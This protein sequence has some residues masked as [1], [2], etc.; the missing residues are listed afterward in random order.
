MKPNFFFILYLVLTFFQIIKIHA[1][2]DLEQLNKRITQLEQKSSQ[3]PED[4]NQ[5]NEQ[6]KANTKK[7]IEAFILSKTEETSEKK[8]LRTIYDDGFFLIGKDDTLKI[9]GWGQID[10]RG[11]KGNHPSNSGFLIRRARFDIRGIL[12]DDFAYRLYFA[13]EGATAKLQEMWVE[14]RKY[15]HARFRVGQIKAPFSLEAMYSA[16]WIHFIERA[17]GPTNFAPFEDI[18]AQLFGKLFDNKVVYALAVFNGK[19]KNRAETNDNKDVAFRLVLQPFRGKEKCWFKQLFFG[20]SFTTGRVD[21][22]IVTKVYR[23]AGRTTF[24]NYAPG[25]EQHGRLLRYGFELEWIKGP[26]SLASEYL[27]SERRRMQLGA[28]DETIQA[29]S[30]YI[31][32]TYVLTGENQ[33]RNRPIK[34]NKNFNPSKNAWGAW[35]VDF[36]CEKFWADSKILSTGLATGTDN[37]C[38]YTGGVIWWPNRHIKAMANLVYNKFDDRITVSTKMLN[39]ETVCLFRVQFEF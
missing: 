21:D 37:V 19:G 35:E 3:V 29:H 20:G 33:L 23:T 36:R 27:Q 38:T 32:L 28:V 34:P 22:T 30:W 1:T 4:E 12:E 31:W 13:F 16:K 39:S 11:F 7:M 2:V 25:V 17:I 9:G 8:Q 10:F 14:Y 26:F 15:P 6:M 24:L 5:L 18:G